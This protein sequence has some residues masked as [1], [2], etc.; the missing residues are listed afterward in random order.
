MRRPLIA[1]LATLASSCSTDP[2]VEWSG[3]VYHDVPAEP[4]DQLLAAQLS[5]VAASCAGSLR[6]VR[7]GEVSFAVW[8]QAR[9]DSSV[10]LMSSRSSDG[11]SW[12]EPVIVDSTDHGILGCD[13][14]PPSIAAD[15]ASGYVHVAYF[16]E[17]N[18]G[19]GV[20]FAHS[21]DS[22]ASFHAPVPI[23]FGKSPSR[24]SVGASGDRVVVAYEDPN[25]AQPVI[26][27]GLSRTMG[28]IFERRLQATSSNGR[29]RQPVVQVDE[30]SIRLWWSEYSGNPAVSATRPR[31]RAGKWN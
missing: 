1:L 27:L 4:V 12:S 20:F 6:I 13:R 11:S 22:A 19:G 26:G 9:S 29:A 18:D 15:S 23:V 25:S 7:I 5:P 3:V 17:P 24:V 31:Y 8:W 14:P 21:M 16:A 10:M 2:S 28:H 30:D